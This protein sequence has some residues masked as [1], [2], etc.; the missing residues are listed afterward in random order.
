MDQSWAA[1]TS[2]DVTV[3][4]DINLDWSAVEPT[5]G[6]WI[7]PDG[8]LATSSRL[9][10]EADAVSLTLAPIQT[11]A[12]RV[13]DDL[14]GRRWDDPELVAR[15]LAALDAVLWSLR[16]VRV[17]TVSVGNEVDG[18]LATDGTAWQAYAG[19]VGRVRSHLAPR[20]IEVGAKLTWEGAQSDAAA[21]VV[22]ASDLVIVS[23][24]PLG[25]GA[26]PYQVR[27]PEVV[28][29]ELEK[30]LAQV[31]PRPVDLAEAGYPSDPSIGGSPQ[32]QAAFVD[33]VYDVW[34]RH[35]SQLRGVCLVWSDDLS[36]DTAATLVEQYG[37]TD[38]GFAAYLGSL[39]L[40]DVD[41]RGKPAWARLA[42]RAGRLR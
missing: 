19:L 39:G 12:V 22:A 27:P 34:D 41:G 21:P 28:A 20:G 8:V 38:P 26:A 25:V 36:A 15:Y 5:P 10:A 30:L 14:S 16:D 9:Y 29:D 18:V 17:E 2:I 40:R 13:P 32:R 1:A 11:N 3:P 37:I 31:A 33:A 6:T 35:P 4:G 7:D 24:Y 42:D 23:Y